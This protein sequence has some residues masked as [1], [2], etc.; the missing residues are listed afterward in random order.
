MCPSFIIMSYI[1]SDNSN[2]KYEGVYVVTKQVRAE[3]P[4]E[5]FDLRF[6]DGNAKYDFSSYN[7]TYRELFKMLISKYVPLSDV[8]NGKEHRYSIPQVPISSYEMKTAAQELKEDLS[9]HTLDTDPSSK[10]IKQ[11]F[12][13]I[14]QDIE[15]Q[16]KNTENKEGN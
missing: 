14:I 10:R 8:G 3:G 2:G 6:V 11:L 5:I 15:N 4:K 7:Q 1:M 9:K 16:L 13:D 12:S